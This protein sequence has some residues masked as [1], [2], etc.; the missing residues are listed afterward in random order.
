MRHI[1]SYSRD[2]LFKN[3]RARNTNTIHLQRNKTICLQKRDMQQTKWMQNNGGRRVHRMYKRIGITFF[4]IIGIS[5]IIITLLIG[6]SHKKRTCWISDERTCIPI[7]TYVEWNKCISD[8]SNVTINSKTKPY[9]PNEW[10]RPRPYAY[11]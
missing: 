6:C 7:K 4:Y 5:L 9:K 3:K 1:H 10:I 8:C 11:P 2:L